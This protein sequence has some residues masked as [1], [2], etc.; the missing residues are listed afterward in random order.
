L[1]TFFHFCTPFFLFVVCTQHY[2]SFSLSNKGFC[3]IPVSTPKELGR[4]PPTTQAQVII[5][6]IGRAPRLARARLYNII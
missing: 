6:L 4:P 1:C 2:F 5:I 3:K